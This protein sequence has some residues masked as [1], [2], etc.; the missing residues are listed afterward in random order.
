MY[1]VR[2]L[3]LR[4]RSQRS[5]PALRGRCCSSRRWP[6][7]RGRRRALVGSPRRARWAGRP[8]ARS[9]AY[10]YIA[11]SGRAGIRLAP[12]DAAIPASNTKLFTT[13]RR[14]ARSA[15]RARWRPRSC[16]AGQLG[17]GGVYRGN[18]YLRGGGD[19]TFGSQRFTS[20]A[21]GG[22]ATVETL[23]GAARPRAGIERVAGRVIGDESLLRQPA[24]RPRL[25][26]RRSSTWVG[27]LSGLGFNRGLS[28]RGRH[29]FQANSAAVRG[30]TA[31]P[32]RSRRRGIAVT[33]APGARPR[34]RPA[35]TARRRRSPPMARLAALTNK[36]SDNYFAETL[37]KDLG[38]ATSFEAAT[39]RPAAGARRVVRAQLSPAARRRSA[40]G[41]STAR[42]C[43]A[44]TGRLALPRG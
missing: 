12:H 44:P 42:A 41:S 19:P 23:A 15:S 31:R 11:D 17:D 3:K 7:R 38:A 43:R 37:V 24:R 39:A 16:G 22:G 32:T 8:A 33:G 36:P 13:A 18:L 21:Y 25:R 28:Q 26:L 40:R 27:P 5:P 4:R 2:A 9:G 29:G 35:P 20:R 1:G 30:R 10:V 6:A 34:R 14:C